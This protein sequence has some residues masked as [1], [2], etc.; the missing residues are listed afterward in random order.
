MDGMPIEPVRIVDRTCGTC[1]LCCKVLE[2]PEL[3]KPKGCWC[4]H[5]TE[6]GCGIYQD[7]PGV[8]RRFICAWLADGKLPDAWKPSLCGMVLVEEDDGRRLIAHVDPADPEAWRREPCYSDLRRWA[9]DG[10][11]RGRQ[12]AVY[13]D[14][15]VIVILPEG[16][17]DLGVVGEDETIVLHHETTPLGRRYKAFKMRRGLA[18]PMAR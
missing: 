5:V 16:D 6:R 2:I 17:S 10:V 7:R 15:R 11:P 9:R 4:V 3:A 1:S 18:R 12:I 14:R 13:I 8:C